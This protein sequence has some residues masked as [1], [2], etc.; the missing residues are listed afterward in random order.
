MKIAYVNTPMQDENTMSPQVIDGCTPKWCVT[1]EWVTKGL[2]LRGHLEKKWDYVKNHPSGGD[3]IGFY[4]YDVMPVHEI[5][6]GDGN[7]TGQSA[8]FV[9]L[10]YMKESHFPKKSMFESLLENSK[11]PQKINYAL[12]LDSPNSQ[13]INEN[14]KDE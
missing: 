14:D 8:M 10:D 11:K 9:R 1:T 2:T 13:K 12:I 5:I 3:V 4:L 6:D 7:Y